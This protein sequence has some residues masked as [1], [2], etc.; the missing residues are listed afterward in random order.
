MLN[1][2][3]TTRLGPSSLTWVNTASDGTASTSGADGKVSIPMYLDGTR[4][5]IVFVVQLPAEGL[6]KATVSQRSVAILAAAD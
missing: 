4:A 1:D 2:G 6:D 3:S 5:D